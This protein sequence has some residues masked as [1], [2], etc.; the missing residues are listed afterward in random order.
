MQDTQ[1]S[2]LLNILSYGEV[3]KTT[4]TE[5]SLSEDPSAVVEI[6]RDYLSDVLAS[7]KA[8]NNLLIIKDQLCHPDSLDTKTNHWT[9]ACLL[10]IGNSHFTQFKINKDG[11]SGDDLQRLRIYSKMIPI[12]ETLKMTNKYVSYMTKAENS[13]PAYDPTTGQILHDLTLVIYDKECKSCTSISTINGTQVEFTEIFQALPNVT[14]KARLDFN[15]LPGYDLSENFMYINQNEGENFAK[16]F[17]INQDYSV[18]VYKDDVK[19]TLNNAV[20][21]LNGNQQDTKTLKLNQ[22]F[23]GT[24]DSNNWFRYTIYV[25]IIVLVLGALVIFLVCKIIKKKKAE[26]LVQ[27]ETQHLEP[28]HKV[29]F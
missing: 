7:N 10:T 1:K 6:R 20:F 26:K 4:W 27:I 15:Y 28:L 19:Q 2:A 14:K 13:L 24:S 29:S 5:I 22:L 16:S 9:V 8:S 23:D 11:M 3:S 12:E 25:C 17:K 21:S 18:T